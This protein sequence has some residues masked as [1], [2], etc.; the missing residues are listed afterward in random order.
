MSKN[1]KTVPLR[2]YEDVS[3]PPPNMSRGCASGALRESPRPSTR[4]P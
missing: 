3:R 1:I 4:T 2:T